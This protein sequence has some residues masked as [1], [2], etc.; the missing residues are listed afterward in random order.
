MAFFSNLTTE[1]ANKTVCMFSNEG[2]FLG[3][4]GDSDGS[5]FQRPLF[6]ISDKTGQLYISDT[7]KVVTY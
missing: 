5:S 4:I 6:I 7:G 2:Q 3:Y 1:R